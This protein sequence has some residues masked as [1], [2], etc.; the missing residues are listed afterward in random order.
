LT[1][2]ATTARV[3]DS[4]EIERASSLGVRLAGSGLVVAAAT[5][6]A[7]WY[8]TLLLGRLDGAASHA[9]DLAF[10]QQLVWNLV[11]GNGLISSFEAGNFLGLHR[12]EVDVRG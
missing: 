3:Q 7:G 9:Y 11:N 10:F 8:L 4:L 6:A 12:I 2:A 1:P 5:G